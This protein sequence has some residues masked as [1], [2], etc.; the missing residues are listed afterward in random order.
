[1]AQAR[2]ATVDRFG[3]VLIPRRVRQA[4]GLLPGSE[5]EIVQDGAA[6]RL[7]PRTGGLLLKKVDGFL[8]VTGEATGDMMSAVKRA[9]EDH[10]RRLAGRRR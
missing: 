10:T 2:P 1:V 5:V 8:V 6:V 7:V 9:R 3:R 4:T